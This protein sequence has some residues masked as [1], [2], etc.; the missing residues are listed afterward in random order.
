MQRFSVCP[1][2]Y[3]DRYPDVQ[4]DMLDPRPGSCGTSA[5]SYVARARS[6]QRARRHT[7]V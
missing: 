3:I 1:C 5:L 6:G 4:R 7:S 2:N